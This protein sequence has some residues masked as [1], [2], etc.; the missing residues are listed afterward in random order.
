MVNNNL[1]RLIIIME[2]EINKYY[3]LYYCCI[4]KFGYLYNLYKN[5]NAKHLWK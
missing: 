3:N 1:V 5:K 2:G 4:N